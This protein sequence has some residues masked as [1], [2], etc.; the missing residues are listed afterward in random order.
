M[1]ETEIF[2]IVYP[3]I[4]YFFMITECPGKN[5]KDVICF[6]LTNQA[7]KDYIFYFLVCKCFFRATQDAFS[8]CNQGT[9][10]MDYF[11]CVLGMVM[12][13]EG[14]PYFVFPGKMK[15]WVQKILE[16]PEGALRKFGFVLMFLGLLIVYLGRR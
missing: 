13:I 7:G 8:T 14:I 5:S 15:T 3:V 4:I 12:V 2:I 16:I 1:S 6:L 10:L 9:E 11:L